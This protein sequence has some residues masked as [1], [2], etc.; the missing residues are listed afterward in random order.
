MDFTPHP[1]KYNREAHPHN[2]VIC[3]S[4]PC[5]HTKD[6]EESEEIITLHVMNIQRFSTASLT[7]FLK[8]KY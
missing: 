7:H 2:V 4:Q 8:D 6:I 1:L 3:S 5:L